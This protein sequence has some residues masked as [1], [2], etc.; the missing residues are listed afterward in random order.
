MPT[1]FAK[2]PRCRKPL[3]THYFPDTYADDLVL[4]EKVLNQLCENCVSNEESSKA[5]IRAMMPEIVAAVK[6][7]G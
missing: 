4:V 1:Y 7:A 6:A 3:G 2:C 5:A